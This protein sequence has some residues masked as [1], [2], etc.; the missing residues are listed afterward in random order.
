VLNHLSL[1]NRFLIA[2]LI[3]IVLTIVLLVANNTVIQS[4]TKVLQSIQNSNLP[5]LSEISRFTILLVKNHA[6]FSVLLSS[7]SI[8]LDEEQIYLQGRLILNELHKFEEILIQNQGFEEHQSHNSALDINQLNTF[9]TLYKESVISSIEM[10]TVDSKLA[11]DELVNAN[12]ALEQLSSLLLN[13]S[14]KN[15]KDLTAE[16]KLVE[17][18]LSKHSYTTPLTIFL[19]IAMIISAFYFSNNLSANLNK[20]IQSLISLSK[21]S[22]NVQLEMPS[23]KY[24]LSL[25]NAVLEFKYVLIQLKEQKFALDQ[26]SIVAI[27]DLK[28]AITYANEKFS[29]ISGYSSKELLGQNHRILSSGHHSH[30]FWKE[31]YRTIAQGNVWHAEVCNKAKGDHLYWVKTTIVP[32]MGDS[33]K[34]ISYIA[35]RTDITARKQAEIGLL[36]STALAEAANK[37]KSEFLSSMSHELRT[38]LNAIIGFSHLMSNDLQEPLSSNQN[39]NLKYII[40][41]GKH[42]LSLVNEILE[43]SSIEDGTMELLL[44]D[45]QLVDSVEDVLQFSKPIADE[46][47][48]TLQTLSNLPV[49]IKADATKLKQIFL[50]LINNAIKYNHEY[51]SV[52]IDWYPVENNYIRINVIDTGK[53]IPEEFHDKVFSTFNRLGLENS[54]ISGTGIGLAVTK[55]L[56]NS[57]GGQ[58]GFDS[59]EGKGSTFWFTLPISN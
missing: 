16:A 24:L 13:I 18:S 23:D 59:T 43:L 56:V 50:N 25:T 57:M 17:E 22:T 55:K 58:I 33:K 5:Q 6:Q 53:G 12:K 52:S 38:P 15:I 1:R 11:L 42:L 54:A 9:Y 46:D 30:D 4:H 37:A 10:S 19:I 41:G 47:G 48:V 49:V 35:I 8:Q 14:E 27:T 36:K 21:G 2:P 7:S 31:M 39:E 40:S 29:S 26:H 51:G 34:P 28:G 44:E 3:G 32:F 45:V 20:I